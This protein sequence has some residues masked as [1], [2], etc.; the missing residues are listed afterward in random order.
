[1][2]T[3]NLILVIHIIHHIQHNKRII[4]TMF[5]YGKKNRQK[6]AAST[7]SSTG[8]ETGLLYYKV[9]KDGVVTNFQAW[10]RGWKE[11]KIMEYDVT[12]QEGLREYKREEFDLDGRL[13][14]LE[15]EPLVTISKD[16]WV[17]TTV[18]ILELEAESDTTRRG[19][20]ERR[21]MAQWA[22]TQAIRNAEIQARND[23][24][25]KKRD[26]IIA[27]GNDTTRKNTITTLMGKVL[28]DM[29]AESR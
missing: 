28:G 13:R 11:H 29:T 6:Q 19:Y 18:D 23:A 10:L 21:L 2:S 12:Y 26:E 24:T 16:F 4:S 14:A 27:I 25:K 1:L 3:T 22:R 5:G 8:N 15:Y 17:P 20:V 9:G 7:S